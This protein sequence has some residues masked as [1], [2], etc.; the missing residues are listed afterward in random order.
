LR[1]VSACFNAFVGMI[2]FDAFASFGLDGDKQSGDNLHVKRVY[3]AAYPVLF[4]SQLHT[5]W[6]TMLRPPILH[7]F[8]GYPTS[9]RGEI[10]KDRGIT[11]KG[12]SL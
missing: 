2:T 11:R 9:F 3:M 12:Q 4:F 10:P 5:V 6:Q 7:K 8:L 1:A